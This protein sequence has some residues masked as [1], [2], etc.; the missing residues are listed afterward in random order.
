MFN[1]Q[2]VKVGCKLLIKL[3]VGEETKR[4]ERADKEVVYATRI[5]LRNKGTGVKN[6]TVGK[7]IE[8]GD[9]SIRS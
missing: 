3:T 5:S 9:G 4:N 1:L 7:R 8:N 6:G 2:N